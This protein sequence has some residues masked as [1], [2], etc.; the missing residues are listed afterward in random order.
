MYEAGGVW[1]GWLW[2]QG[3]GVG[4]WGGCGAGPWGGAGSLTMPPTP[5]WRHLNS[6]VAQSRTHLTDTSLGAFLA[7]EKRR[8]DDGWSHSD[9]VIENDT[10]D[11][12]DL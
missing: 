6:S 5:F 12:D 9:D 2:G 3:R 11:V 7:A 4:L 10:F 1:Q 8:I